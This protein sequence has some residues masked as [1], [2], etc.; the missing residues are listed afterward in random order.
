MRRR[1]FL[2][3]T[4]AL[5]YLVG[6]VI[7]H[8]L[9]PFGA[10]PVLD[11]LTP[12]PA[13]RWVQPPSDL[14]AGNEKPFGG[15][16]S[17]KF[18][19]G[20]SQAGAFTIRDSQLSMILDPGA[21]PASGNPSGASISISPMGSASVRRPPG[22]QIDGNVYRITVKEEPKGTAV[23]RFSHPQRVILVYPADKSFVKPQ[24]LLVSSIDGKVWTKIKTQDSTIQQQASG[25][26]AAPALV[27]VVVPVKSGTATSH[28]TLYVLIAIAILVLAGLAWWFLRRSKSSNTP[29]RRRG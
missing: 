18:T 21:V 14:A 2:G 5:L 28:A 6:A 4:V 8:Q 1:L 24:H 15:K 27:A 19:G 12:P 29:T 22:Y 3:G 16:F 25:L 17:L 13:Y 11:G 26:I 7:T 20:R 10:R 9:D 23:S